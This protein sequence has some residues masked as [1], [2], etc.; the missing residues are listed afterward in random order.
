MIDRKHSDDFVIQSEVKPKPVMIGSH[1]SS[2]A[3]RQLHVLTSL[4]FDWLTR[5]SAF[6]VIG[7]NDYFC[8][9]FTTLSWKHVTREPREKEEVSSYSVLR[10]VTLSEANTSS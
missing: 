7:D 9:G 3:L 6:S 8:F 2:R 5:L 10:T 1:K 4:S